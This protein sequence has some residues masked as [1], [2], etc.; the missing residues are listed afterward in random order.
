MKEQNEWGEF[1]PIKY[2]PFAYNET[3]AQEYFPLTKEEAQQQGYSWLE[4]PPAEQNKS[5]QP[6]D[7]IQNINS[8]VL[9]QKFSCENCSKNYKIIPQELTFYKTHQLPLPHFCPNCRHKNRMDMRLPRK[10]WNRNCFKCQQSIETSY[11]P[12]RPEKVY[13]EKCYLEA[14]Y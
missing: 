5:I 12:Q 6:V 7:N 3:L 11:A 4:D 10:L 8:S 2:S 1:F 9:S 13:C 14:V